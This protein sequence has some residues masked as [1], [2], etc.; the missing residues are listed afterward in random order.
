[1]LTNRRIYLSP[2][3]LIGPGA[4]QDLKTDLETLPYTKALFVTDKVLVKSGVAANALYVFA[5]G[6]SVDVT[7]EDAIAIY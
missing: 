4:L 5:G 6:N 1:M 2:V 7:L 3:N